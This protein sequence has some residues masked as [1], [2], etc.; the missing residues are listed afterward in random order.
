VLCLFKIYLLDRL[1]NGG[2]TYYSSYATV[3]L[4]ALGVAI[5]LSILSYHFFEK[6]ILALKDV[7]TSEGFFARVW[8]KLLLFFNPSSA[9]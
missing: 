1:V 4:L 2:N 6:K 7:M 8:R 9:R 5:I 3:S